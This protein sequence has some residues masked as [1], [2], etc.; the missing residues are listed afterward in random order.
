MCYGLVE[1]GVLT[2]VNVAGRYA[3]NGYEQV[4]NQNDPP[5]TTF[6]GISMRFDPA[7]PQ[8]E[9][10]FESDGEIVGRIVGIS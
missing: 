4:A 10:R 8:D 2:V 1:E 6:K 3:I 9:L 5:T 7:V